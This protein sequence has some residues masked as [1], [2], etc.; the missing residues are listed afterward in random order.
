MRA[1]TGALLLLAWS[2]TALQAQR[3]SG[4]II[5]ARSGEPLPFA[6]ALLADGDEELGR[7]LADTAGRFSI[8]LS[9]LAGRELLVTIRRI[10]YRP[11]RRLVQIPSSG[12]EATVEVALEPVAAQLEDVTSAARRRAR[13][14]ATAGFHDRASKG[15]GHFVTEEDILERDPRQVTDVLLRVPGVS[16]I[17]R[18]D[19]SALIYVMRAQARFRN[20]LCPPK[21][22]LDGV[23][24][25]T[26][27]T[28]PF[29][30]DAFLT[31]DVIAGIEIY[32][33]PAETPVMFGGAE[34]D[35]GVIVIWTK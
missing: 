19:G 2:G 29:D 5:D 33:G 1:I 7:T 24:V 27:T 15:F 22:M 11:S 6:Q 30:F 35:C 4:R 20:S 13:R 26:P 23:V 9:G 12:E 3:L 17:G 28:D 14:L 32:R 31:P 18:S 10:G 16:R 21:V 34:S 8:A 25:G